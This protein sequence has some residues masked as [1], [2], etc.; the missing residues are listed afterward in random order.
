LGQ[1]LADGGRLYR[2]GVLGLPGIFVG[3]GA[4]GPAAPLATSL[5]VVPCVLVMILAI[6]SMIA[7]SFRYVARVR[8]AGI[9]PEIRE[10]LAAVWPLATAIGSA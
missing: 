4:R 8:A 6:C 9:S 5:A 3:F 1:H 10:T 7:K 2:R